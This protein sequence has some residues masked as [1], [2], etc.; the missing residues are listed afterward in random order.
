MTTILVL[1]IIFVA[2]ILTVIVG[3]MAWAIR[4]PRSSAGTPATARSARAHE[5]AVRAR[6]ARADRVWTPRRSA[7]QVGA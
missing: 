5:Q 4:T 2:F 7:S 6:A 3:G 1:N